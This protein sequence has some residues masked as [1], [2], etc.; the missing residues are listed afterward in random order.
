MSQKFKR[1]INPRESMG[2]GASSGTL[3]YLVEG[4]IYIN[5]PMDSPWNPPENG[6][7]IHSRKDVYFVAEAPE[8]MNPED[9]FIDYNKL[10]FPIKDVVAYSTRSFHK[11]E[12]INS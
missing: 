6:V 4:K 11:K 1:G 7:E 10:D 8:S 3:Y 9:V 12:I 5:I 2:I